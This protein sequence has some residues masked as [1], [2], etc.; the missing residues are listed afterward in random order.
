MATASTSTVTEQAVF[1]E[2]LQTDERSASVSAICSESRA[3]LTAE[4]QDVSRRE[5]GSV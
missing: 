4:R 1:N 3:T 2:P 5:S